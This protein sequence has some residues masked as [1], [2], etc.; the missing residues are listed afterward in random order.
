METDVQVTHVDSKKFD[1]VQT[2][3]SIIC[4]FLECY[5]FQQLFKLFIYW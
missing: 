1:R 5:F 2:F 3:D 4:S